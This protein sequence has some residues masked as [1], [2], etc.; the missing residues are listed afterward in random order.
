MKFFYNTGWERDF[1]QF[2]IL[3]SIETE[4]VFYNKNDLEKLLRE[5]RAVI[6]KNIK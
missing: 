5:L 4:M 2:D 3:K 1:L 6:L